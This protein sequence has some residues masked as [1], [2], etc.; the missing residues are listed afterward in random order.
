MPVLAQYIRTHR[1]KNV[2]EK[3]LTVMLRGLGGESKAMNFKLSGDDRF[4]KRRLWCVPWDSK[5]EIYSS[6]Y[7]PDDA[8]PDQ[9]IRNVKEHTFEEI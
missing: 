5:N 3:T 9:P 2:D 1:G 6:D 7:D 8:I 4:Q